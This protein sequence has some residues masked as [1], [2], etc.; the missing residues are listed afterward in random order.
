MFY[1]APVI[2]SNAK[3]C[4]PLYQ[5]LESYLVHALQS[6]LKFLCYKRGGISNKTF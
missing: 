1:F 3:R 2:W 5:M 6:G 4:L